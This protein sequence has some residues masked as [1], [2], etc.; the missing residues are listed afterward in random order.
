MMGKK[1]L[2][3]WLSVLTVAFVLMAGGCE[4]E[5]IDVRSIHS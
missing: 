3:A 2:I 1:R 5:V 4:E